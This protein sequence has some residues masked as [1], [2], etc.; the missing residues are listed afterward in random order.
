MLGAVAASF[1]FSHAEIMA[2]N[3][4]ELTFWN[5]IAHDINE[6]LKP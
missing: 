5:E 2:F 3:A 6:Q 1:S 4:D